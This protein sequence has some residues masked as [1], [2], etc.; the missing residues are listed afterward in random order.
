M[1]QNG[2]CLKKKKKS[3]GDQRNKVIYTYVIQAINRKAGL[4]DTISD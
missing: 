4:E 1:K 3:L 2:Q